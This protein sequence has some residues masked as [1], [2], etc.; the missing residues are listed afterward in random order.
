M[1]HR[2]SFLALIAFLFAVTQSTTSYPILT[3]KWV[4][5]DQFEDAKAHG[6]RKAFEKEG[7]DI[8]PEPLKAKYHLVPSW[9]NNQNDHAAERGHDYP[10][11]HQTSPALVPTTLDIM[12]EQMHEY[13]DGQMQDKQEQK[14]TSINSIF[15]QRQNHYSELLSYLHAKNALNKDPNHSTPASFSL[16]SSAGHSVSF[17]SYRFSLP[18]LGSSTATLPRYPL[19]GIFTMVIILLAMVWIAIFTIG[20]VELGSYLWARRREAQVDDEEV[21]HGEEESVRLEDLKSVPF[22][23]VFPP[24]GI[25]SSS[26]RA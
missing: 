19:P 17:F 10:Y 21:E 23:V 12:P 22:T 13:Y 2:P 6:L 14:S 25:R 24:Q 8:L 26:V 1:H 7:L 5:A 11:T 15:E 18:T 9:S 3:S 20:L 4:K 16:A